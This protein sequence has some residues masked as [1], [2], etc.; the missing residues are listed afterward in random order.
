MQSQEGAL[1][2]VPR[3]RFKM[4]E[5]MTGAQPESDMSRYSQSDRGAAANSDDVEGHNVRTSGDAR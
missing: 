2:V 5:G 4:P 1:N 3:P